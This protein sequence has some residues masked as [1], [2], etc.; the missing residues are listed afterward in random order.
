MTDFATP[1]AELLARPLGLG[2]EERPL[3]E[4]EAHEFINSAFDTAAVDGKR[5]LVIIPDATRTAPIALL[6]RLLYDAIGSRVE[7]LDYLIALGT[8]QPMSDAAIAKMVGM[9]EQQRAQQTPRSRVFNHAWDDPDALTL[10]GVITP[11]EM[12]ELTDGLVERETPVQINRKAFEY[13][14]LLIIGPVFP[15]EVAGFSG[16]AKY[17]FPGISGAEI[18]DSSHWLGALST[19]YAT[20]GVKDTPVRRVLH[21]AAGFVTS[22]KPVTCLKLAMKGPDLHGLY[23][24]SHLSAWSAA[25][26]LSAELNI[27]WHEQPYRSVLSMPSRQY[28][29]LWTAA[30]AMYKTEP[31]VA[32]G[33]E[34]IIYAPHLT[35][36][37]VTHGH[38]IEQVGYHVRDWFLFDWERFKDIPWTTLA[39]STHVKG[40]GRMVDGVERARIKVTLA[41]GIPEELCRRVNLGWRDPASINPEDWRNR[42]SEGLLLVE[43]AGENLYRLRS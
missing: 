8:H 31:V 26:D 9:N 18:I 12:R 35:E 34:I 22:R 5:V 13:D 24:G 19:S 21:H 17:L 10:A 37:S 36:I 40:A 41:T 3:T 14:H 15:H 38:L 28:A 25:A 27:N 6:Y 11:T 39:H 30:K 43:N 23:T 2:F 4:S 16:G 20:I 7:Q 29:D 32:D 42:E 1:E 33:G